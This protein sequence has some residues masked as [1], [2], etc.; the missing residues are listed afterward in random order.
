[1]ACRSCKMLPTPPKR[2]SYLVQLSND[3]GA[4]YDCVVQTTCPHDLQTWID[5]HAGDFPIVHPKVIN[6]DAKIAAH[7]P[8]A[9]LV[10]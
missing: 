9:D 1:M 6:I 5:E 10:N 3:Q 2:Q 8:L 7:I 4:K